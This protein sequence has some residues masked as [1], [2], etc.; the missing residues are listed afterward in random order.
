MGEGKS[1]MVGIGETVTAS[2]PGVKVEW[3]SEGESGEA[4]TQQLNEEL[5]NKVTE[6]LE[7]TECNVASKKG[8]KHGMGRVNSE[9]DVVEKEE[10][11]RKNSLRGKRMPA[12]VRRESIQWE[13]SQR[14][15]FSVQESLL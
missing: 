12:W 2:T 6:S 9:G 3:L 15:I 5:A 8:E 11:E 4:R 1:P 14:D 13:S 10:N 7:V